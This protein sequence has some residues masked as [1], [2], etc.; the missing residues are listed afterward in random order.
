MIDGIPDR[1][2]LLAAL[3]GERVTELE[4]LV[5]AYQGDDVGS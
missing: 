5:S 4:V 3:F 2:A 1:I